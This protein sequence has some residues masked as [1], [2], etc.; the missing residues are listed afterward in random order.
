MKT[1]KRYKKYLAKL[2]RFR[3]KLKTRY[4]EPKQ[5]KLNLYDQEIMRTEKNISSLENNK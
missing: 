2:I 4:E 1:I 5:E 3:Q